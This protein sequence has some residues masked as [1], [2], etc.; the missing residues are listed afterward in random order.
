MNEIPQEGSRSEPDL[1]LDAVQDT[2]LPVINLSAFL[3][4]SGLVASGG[5]AKYLIQDSE[6]RVNGEIET[7]RR[8]KLLASDRVAIG[9]EELG[10][11]QVLREINGG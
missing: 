3:K 6:V 2:E 10:V 9:D 5:E 11:G 8:K 4:L 7:R 1:T